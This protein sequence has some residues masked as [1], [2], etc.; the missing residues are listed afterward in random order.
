MTALIAAALILSGTPARPQP[1]TAR[2]LAVQYADGRRTVTPI[3][4][5]GRVSWT[6]LFPR[7]A[8]AVTDRD[9]LRLFAMQ[10]EE[11]LEPGGVAVTVALLYGSPHERRIPV[12]TV[13]VSPD[14]PVRV[15]ALEA[16]GIK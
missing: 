3:S 8:G 7:I 13:H 5:A 9:G 4:A 15:D 14:R 6:P 2:G 10:Y 11:A 12:D 1:E 16:F